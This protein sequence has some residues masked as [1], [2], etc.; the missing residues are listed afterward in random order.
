MVTQDLT[1]ASRHQN[2]RDWLIVGRSPYVHV[3]VTTLS[4]ATTATVYQLESP[5]LITSFE[6]EGDGEWVIVLIPGAGAVPGVTAKFLQNAH[7]RIS[8]SV[9]IVVVLSDEAAATLRETD[10][11]G[12]DGQFAIGRLD[13]HH[14]LVRPSIGDLL[15]VANEPLCSR[16]RWKTYTNRNCVVEVA[17]LLQRATDPAL[18][19]PQKRQL[20]ADALMRL[21]R[22]RN[23]FSVL[24]HE[25]AT[26]GEILELISLE[27]SIF[28]TENHKL[29]RLREIVSLISTP[30]S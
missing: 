12:L 17:N 5:A 21:R 19:Q 18:S 28:L 13:G 20:I 2:R 25:A 24:G 6:A 29:N 7:E 3:L 26:I 23:W 4:T 11:F 8:D 16:D 15:R 10:V 27:M 9:V 14:V 22:V 1:Y 30:E